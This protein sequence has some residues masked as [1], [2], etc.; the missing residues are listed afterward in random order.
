MMFPLLLFLPFPFFILEAANV[1][2]DCPIRK[3]N[4]HLSIRSHQSPMGRRSSAICSQENREDLAF[5]KNEDFQSPNIE[6]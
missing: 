2:T 1:P 5:V 3:F 4:D 6:V